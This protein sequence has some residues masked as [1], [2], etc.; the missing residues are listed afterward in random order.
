MATGCTTDVDMLKY[1][2]HSKL[3]HIS[4]LT[5]HSFSCEANEPIRLFITTSRE[6]IRLDFPEHGDLKPQN[7]K[8]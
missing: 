3:N 1:S 8:K 7:E 6:T 4:C 2:L 5:N